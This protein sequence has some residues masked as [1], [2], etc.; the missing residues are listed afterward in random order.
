MLYAD[1]MVLL[2]TSARGRQAQLQELEAHSQENS[3]TV[4]LTKTKAMLL[5]GAHSEAAAL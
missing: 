2:A 4:N 3:L 1:D 5:A